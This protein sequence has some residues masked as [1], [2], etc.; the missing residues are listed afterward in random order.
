MA[1]ALVQRRQHDVE[2]L[3]DAVGEIEPAVR[4]DVHL[5]AVQDRDLA[6]TA[7][8]ARAISSAWRSIAVHRQIAR[9]GRVRRVV[10]DRHVLVAERARTPA[11]SPRPC[12]GR[13]STSCACGDRRGC[14]ARETSAGSAPLCGRRESRRRRSRI[15]GG[16]NGRSERRVDLLFGRGRTAARRRRLRRPSGVEPP[17]RVA[18]ASARS[19]SRCAPRPGQVQQGGARRSDG[20]GSGRRPAR[21]RSAGTARRSPRCRQ[22][23][24]VGQLERASSM[25]ARR[26]V[27][28]RDD[29]DVAD[30]VLSAAQR[31]DRLG[32]RDARRRS[33]QRRAS[34]RPSPIARPSGMRGIG[35]AQ[36]RAAPP[37]SPP[38]SLRR[39]PARR[40]RLSRDGRAPD[41]RPTWRRAPGAAPPS[42]SIVTAPDSNSQRRSAGR[43][44]IADSSS[45]QPPASNMCRSC[46][47][48][49]RRRRPAAGSSSS[50]PRS[51]SESMPC[52]RT[53]AAAR[54]NSAASAA[55]PRMVASSASCSR[56]RR[57]GAARVRGVSR[58]SRV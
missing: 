51:A 23:R 55:S 16:M 57:E 7:R 19:A 48:H 56:V 20:S 39:S 43:S 10:G 46:V 50:G 58:K 21:D 6:D 22:P 36:R 18:A 38:R 44:A 40:G 17:V 29:L 34:A 13:R 49:V 2:A 42:C 28:R 25:A 53:S 3:E 30:R 8:A 14:R 5:A 54:A 1:G 32:P 47:Q 35:R 27:G 24:D 11:P 9:R 12:R 31:A 26:I 52:A 45:T 15:S 41:R 4:Q 37:R 33:Q